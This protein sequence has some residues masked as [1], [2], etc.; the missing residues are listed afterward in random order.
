M[1]FTGVVNKK[2]NQVSIRCTII[3]YIHENF[4]KNN[5]QTEVKK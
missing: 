4:L 5:N 1:D 2:Y 3:I